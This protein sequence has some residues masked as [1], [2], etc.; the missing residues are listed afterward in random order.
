MRSIRG[1]RC[2]TVAYRTFPRRRQARHDG[3]RSEHGLSAVRLARRT[4]RVGARPRRQDR[5][6]PWA[7]RERARLCQAA[8]DERRAARAQPAGP[9]GVRR[10]QP[11]PG[12]A[13]ARRLPAAAARRP[14]LRAGGRSDHRDRPR[15]RAGRPPAP[16]CAARNASASSRTRSISAGSTGSPRHG[17]GARV[18]LAAGIGRDD[19][20]LL[21][22]RAGSK[23]TRAFTIWPPRS[24][25]SP[26][27][28]DGCQRD[29]GAGS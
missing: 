8:R 9:R 12:E 25:R 1:S 7:R 10:D 23:R 27:T 24:A 2:R 5:H 22:R 17:D 14:H 18:R 26:R 16:P 6:R 3:D 19:V 4:A 29:D 13:Q 20:V 28:A 11:R 15:A 21:E